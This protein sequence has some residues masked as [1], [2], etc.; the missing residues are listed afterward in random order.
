MIINEILMESEKS[1]ICKNVVTT[2]LKM[3]IGYLQIFDCI[4]H[5]RM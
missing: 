4:F 2:T 3:S 1:K 5:R